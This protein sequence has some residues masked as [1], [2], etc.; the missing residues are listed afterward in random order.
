LHLEIVN[1]RDEECWRINEERSRERAI[2]RET[3]KHD[4][5][6]GAYDGRSDDGHYSSSGEGDDT[7]DEDDESEDDE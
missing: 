5:R 4:V 6:G 1:K 2:Q 3:R 7:D